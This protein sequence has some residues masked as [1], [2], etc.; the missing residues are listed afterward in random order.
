MR[1]YMQDLIDSGKTIDSARAIYDNWVGCC[2]AVYAEE[3]GT[4]DY[5][6]LHGHLVNAQM[7][8]KQRMSIMVDENLGAMNMPTPQRNAHPAG[9]P[10]GDPPREQAAAP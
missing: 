7:A 6:E 2:E 3:V 4:P 5:A 8:L 10:P 1:G 9:P